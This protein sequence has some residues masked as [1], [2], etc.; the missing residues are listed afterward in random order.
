MLT[1]TAAETFAQEW[2]AAWNGH[3]L[4]RILAHYTDDV[5]LDSPFIPVVAGEP[6]GV[7][8]G[9]RAVGAY[10]AKALARTPELRF[11]LV[12]V[13]WGVRSVVIRY[14]RHDGRRAA[15]WFELDAAGLVLRSA[16]HYAD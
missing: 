7:L 16:A 4:E 11:E 10:W 14:R 12:Q 3:D 13:L 9:K 2:I 8:R 15:E 5:E 6:S 1:R